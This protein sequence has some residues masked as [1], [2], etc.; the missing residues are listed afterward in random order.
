MNDMER[1]FSEPLAW[2]EFEGK[3]VLVTGATGHIASYITFF[4]IYLKRE[5]NIKVDITILCRTPQKAERLFDEFIGK[6]EINVLYQDVTQP[7][8]EGRYDY[9]FHLAGN[10]SPYFI[11][12]DPMGILDANLKG[13]KNVLNLA[14]E[15]NAKV[16]FASTR[17][18][19][20]KVENLSRLT[21]KDFGM[22]DCLDARSCYPESKRAAET[23]LYSAYIQYGIPVY[24]V[25]IAHSYGPGMNT[26]NDGRIMSDLIGNA[27]RKEDIVLKSKGE[28]LRAFCYIS[29]TVSGC[30]YAVMKGRPGEAYNL[31]N[32]TEEIS[33]RELAQEIADMV[34]T[35]VKFDIADDSAVYCNY[36]RVGLD[37]GKIESLGWRPK[38]SLRLGLEKT[39]SCV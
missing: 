35:K 16:F 4:L 30:F 34:E 11:K 29:D 12:N 27:A 22:I 18:V 6:G 33:V 13:T 15:S 1:I 24:I 17:E 38:V 26:Q 39:I 37:T 21:E 7:I 25:R 9:I 5:R 32:E 31:S 23:M 14:K 20:G 19:Y 2:K 8:I 3:R 28:A 10:A 36:A